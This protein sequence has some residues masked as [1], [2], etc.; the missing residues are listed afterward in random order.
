MSVSV[1][2]FGSLLDSSGP[3]GAGERKAAGVFAADETFFFLNG[4]SG[5]NR[6][7]MHG[8]VA[9]GEKILVDRNCHK[10]VCD[11]ITLTGARPEYLPAQRNG[12][13]LPGPVLPGA[14]S[15]ETGRTEGATYAVVTNS[16]YDGFCYDTNRAADSFAASV[17]DLHFDEAWFG[18]AAFLPL[19]RGRYAMAVSRGEDDQLICS[20]QSAHKVL[21]AL[22]QSSMIHVRARRGRVD[23]HR[24]NLT[25]A[26][27][28]STSSSYPMLA[29]LDV[30][31]TMLEGGSGPVLIDDVV[32]EAVRFRQGVSAKAETARREDDWFFDIWQPPEVADP[33]DGKRYSFGN[34]P[35]ELLRT[36]PDCW[37]L[38]PAEDWHGFSG[39][40]ICSQRWCPDWWTSTRTTT[41]VS[42]CPASRPGRRIT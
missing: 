11:G 35:A 39:V 14:L 21:A 3:I 41:V 2:R 19:Y 18:H 17:R 12:Y 5:A 8:C 6:T 16:T 1:S 33:V 26:M 40:E 13:G 37:V 38:D 36:V 24:F 25:Y 32:R 4:S 28:A 7:I 10:C 22:S 29:G 42:L 34:A 27:H 30:A 31:A 20:A 15:R 23:R 9:R